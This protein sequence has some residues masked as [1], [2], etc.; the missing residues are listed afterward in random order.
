MR[1]REAFG[2]EFRFES[3]TLEASFLGAMKGS[4]ASESRTSGAHPR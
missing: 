4:M 3:A 2:V 1:Q